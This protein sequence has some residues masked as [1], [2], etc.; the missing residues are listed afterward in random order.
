MSVSY[1][2]AGESALRKV[3]RCDLDD[4]VQAYARVQRRFQERLAAYYAEENIQ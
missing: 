1:P 3:P 4:L 2:W